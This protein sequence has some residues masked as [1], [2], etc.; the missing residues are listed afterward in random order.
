MAKSLESHMG[1]TPAPMAYG[2]PQPVYQQNPPPGGYGQ[3]VPAFAFSNAPPQQ[4]GAYPPAPYPPAPVS[5]GGAPNMNV[6][7]GFRGPSPMP[8]PGTPQPYQLQQQQVQQQQVLPY[9]STG[10]PQPPQ[11][12]QQQ[13]GYGVPI[14]PMNVNQRPIS[15]VYPAQG[16]PPATG[17]TTPPRFTPSPAPYGAPVPGAPSSY[18]GPGGL[19]PG[20]TQQRPQS[21]GGPPPNMAS[22]APIVPPPQSATPQPLQQLG[23]STQQSALPNPNWVNGATPPHSRPTSSMGVQDRHNITNSLSGL[24]FNEPAPKAQPAQLVVQL[25]TVAILTVQLNGGS[26]REGVVHSRD[27]GR[28][29]AWCKDVLLTLEK[30]LASNSEGGSAPGGSAKEILL[31]PGSSSS[32]P[33]LENDAALIKLSEAAVSTILAIL[34]PPLPQPGPNGVLQPY[35]AEALFLRGSLVAGGWFPERCAA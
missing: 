27:P 32:A 3:P 12:P 22:L 1:P 5:Y 35:I 16:G 19:A 21:W 28:K 9:A 15:M 11:Y 29:I 31:G 18:P 25:P 23:V 14:P 20:F 2:Q 17:F 24:T 30:A 4:P 7:P 6:N 33:Q 8:Y 13:P 10:I 26:G 34:T